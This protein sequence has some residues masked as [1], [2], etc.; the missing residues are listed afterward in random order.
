MTTASS[1]ALAGG[2]SSAIPRRRMIAYWIVTVF[3]AGNAAVAGAMDILR[4][5]PVFGILAHLGYPAYFGA[6]LGTWKALGAV[7][8][9]VPGYPR[10]KEWAYAGMFIDYTAAATS[11]VSVGDATASNLIGPILSVAFLVASWTLR[12]ASRRLAT[13]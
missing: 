5:Q 6:I 2:K 8:L 3:I 9:L 13:R 4:I 12:P 11:Y 10:V 7:A 1:P